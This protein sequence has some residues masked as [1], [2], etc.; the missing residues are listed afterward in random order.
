MYVYVVRWLQR[1]GG[2]TS[3]G[4]FEVC[5]ANEDAA[6][7]QML[8]DW[9]NTRRDWSKGIPPENADIVSAR[10]SKDGD[11]CIIELNDGSCD[12]HEWWIDKL[13][14]EN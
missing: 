7:R 6:R 13:E 2:E 5:N 4:N 9:E 11:W 10:V 14:L 12:Y 1:V 3:C 8:Q